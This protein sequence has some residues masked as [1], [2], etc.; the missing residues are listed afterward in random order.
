MNQTQNPIYA[1]ENFFYPESIA[2]IGASSNPNKPGGL[3]IGYLLN[4]G[5]EGKI[6]PVNPARESIN[7][8]KCYPSVLDIPDKVDLAIV[9]VV[10][11]DVYHTLEECVAKGIRAAVIFSAGFAEV[12]PE[13]LALQQRLTELAGK[14]GLRL[15]G[16]NCVGLLNANNG[17]MATFAPVADLPPVEP[18]V[19]GFVTQSGTFG[20]L[21][22][23]DCLYKGVGFSYFVSVGNEADLEFAD[24]LE[25]MIHDPGTKLVGGYMEGAKDTVKLR[26]VAEEAL[27]KE[28]P[29]LIMKAGSTAAGSRAAASHTGSLAGSDSIYNAFFKQTGMIRINLHTEVI[30]FAP[31]F[32]MGKPPKGRNVAIVSGSGGRGVTLSDCCET[33]GLNVVPLRQETRDRLESILPAFASTQNPV[34][35][36]AAVMTRPELLLESL[37]IVSDDPDVDI[38]LTGMNF[39]GFDSSHPLIREFI[40]FYYHIQNNTDKFMLVS[41]FVQP[42]SEMDSG[43]REL[44]QAGMHLVFDWHENIKAVSQLATYY[45]TLQKRKQDKYRV[46]AP[47]VKKPDLSGLLKPGETLSES[48][49]KAVLEKYG[50]PVT[51]E[52]MATSASEAVSQAKTI[53]YPVVL[54][55]DS[56][57]ILH[58]TEAGSVK[59]NLKNDDEVRAAYHEVISNAR[60]YKPDAR[61]NGVSVQ[62]ML[63]EGTEVIVGVTRDPAFGPVIM[64]GLGGIFVEVLK[65]V[66]FRVAPLSPGDASDMIEEIKGF[67]VLKG[68]RGKPPVD[69]EAIADVIL[70]IS[71]LVTDYRDSIEELDINPLIVYPRGIKAADALLVVRK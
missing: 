7:G 19:L 39:Q 4:K 16:P 27:R 11:A 21:I 36:T 28:K 32:Q 1:M 26:R 61:I 51:R 48:A 38:I 6:Y 8:L 56:P 24:F 47:G 62:E 53:G 69:I 65:D 22:Y 33:L 45:E 17:V 50:I 34:D 3:P 55:V 42:G 49:A 31:L 5:Y 44:L 64:F 10:A 43:G 9:S 70:K 13:G 23:N 71:A 2:I 52:A 68:V 41:Y 18:K 63:P 20:T 14:T 67:A 59:L 12:G 29:V 25:Y 35:L 15:A 30:H 58:K 37:K 54:K 66:S 60:K 40:D 46:Q 57:D